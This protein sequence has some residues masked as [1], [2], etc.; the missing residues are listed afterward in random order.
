[1]LRRV[2]AAGWLML[3]TAAARSWGVPVAECEAADGV[4]SHKGANKQAT[5]GQL[6]SAAARAAAGPEDRAVKI[7]KTSRSSAS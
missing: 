7:R 5:Y 4:V 6:A 3:V 2:G 1:M